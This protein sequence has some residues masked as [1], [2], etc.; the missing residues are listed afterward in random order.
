MAQTLEYNIKV[1]AGGAERTLADIENELHEL[2]EEIKDVGINS[3]AFKVAT[4]NL[5]ALEKELEA[6]NN[7]IEGLKFEDKLQAADG[8]AKVFA[9]SL[10]AAVGVLGTLGIESEA[11]G[12]FEEKAASAIAVG[13]GIKDVSEG[14]VQFTSVM[15]KSG[16]AAKLF[17]NITK[18]A[19]IATGIG[20]FVIALGTVIA[21][22]DDIVK[23]VNKAAEKFPFVGKAIDGIKGAF[24]SL[25]EAAR[26][27]LEF[28]GI[29]PDEAERAQ[30]ALLATTN[31]NIT[32]LERELAIAQAAGESAEELYNLRRRLAEE[33]LAALEADGA[34]EAEI[35][36]KN[37]E[38]LVLEAAERKRKMD[39][40][41]GEDP[42]QVREKVQTV[43]AIK[44]QGLK[45]LGTQEIE[46]LTA[47]QINKKIIS[48]QELAEREAFIQQSIAV[49]QK[50]DMARQASLDNV[51][52]L[53]GAE[54]KVGRAALIAK[55]VLLAKELIMEA[56]STITFASLKGAEATAAT[57]TGAAKTAAVGFPQNIPLLI[58]YAA[59]AAGIISAV[60]S[61]VRGAKKAAG[62]AGAG[63]GSIPAPARIPGGRGASAPSQQPTVPTGFAPETV[64]SQQTIRAYVVGGDVTTT[65]EADAK[66]NAKRTLG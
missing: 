9:G 17:G 65:Q 36:A 38:L 53:A 23:G 6:V 55:Q 61:A 1:N 28:L 48:D 37:T 66:L 29:I 44:V 52:Y 35:Y 7:E 32:Q 45:D 16:I 46:V 4:K 40:A 41:A 57:A 51:I 20:A 56:K 64:A 24:D 27:V 47:D 10:T 14:F 30:M 12:E 3:D 62:E 8:A 13:L 49:Q 50:L 60:V 11:F 19:L 26:P 58:A 54:S 59:Q 18:T 5:Q 39:E 63:G 42:E 2:N 21:Y 43:N 34:E 31:A 22:W 33:Q 15:K 25:F